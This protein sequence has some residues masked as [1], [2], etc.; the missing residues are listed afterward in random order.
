MI[1][2]ERFYSNKV[3]DNFKISKINTMN[4]GTEILLTMEPR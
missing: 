1:L 4:N 3:Q 2:L